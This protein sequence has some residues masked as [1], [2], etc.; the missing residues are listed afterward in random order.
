M[1]S[2]LCCSGKYQS[3]ININV[4]NTTKCDSTNCNLTFYYK[5]NDS[6][7]INNDSYGVW[8]EFP[9]R[10][11]NIIYNSQVY[12][13]R[14]ALF[15]DPNAHRFNNDTSKYVEL[16]LLHYN[17][18]ETEALTISVMIRRSNK[19]TSS[20]INSKFYD[21]FLHDLPKD[22][23]DTGS[24]IIDMTGKNWNMFF[25]LPLNKDFYTYEQG[26]PTQKGECEE[27][28]KWIIFKTPVLI[29]TTAWAKLT[30]RTALHNNLSKPI[31]INNSTVFFV[32]NPNKFNFTYETELFKK[33]VKKLGNKSLSSSSSTSTLKSK[34]TD[35]PTST[36]SQKNTTSTSNKQNTSTT[37]KSAEGKNNKKASK[38][39]DNKILKGVLISLGILVVVG[40]I[41]YFVMSSKDG[42]KSSSSKS[43]SFGNLNLSKVS[44]K[45][46]KGV[47]K[48]Q[49]MKVSSDISKL[50]DKLS[51][52]K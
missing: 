30:E 39:D 36:K 40:L 21:M 35:S 17:Y 9:L 46:F 44:A 7:K 31:K 47:K 49:K 24:K 11:N 28:V 37:S 26:S 2:S 14:S 6:C 18:N 16:Q 19:A 15:V 22:T 33:S 25:G 27:N 3:P 41:V 23:S 32:K 42:K 4:G 8:I 50:G 20:S 1:S 45:P 12:T 43:S 10:N 29:N 52:M 5:N 34:S 38:T 48:F 51:N 13:L